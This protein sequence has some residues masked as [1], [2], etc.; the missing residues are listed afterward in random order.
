MAEKKPK[1]P[2]KRGIAIPGRILTAGILIILQIAFFAAIEMS[3]SKWVTAAE[4]V[5]RI[6][7]LVIVFAICTNLL[8]FSI[9]FIDSSL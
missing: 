3:V 2:H 6:I 9:T 7:S 4:I 8:F 1:K 5:F